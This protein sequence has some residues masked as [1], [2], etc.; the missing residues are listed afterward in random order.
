MKPLS[1]D[2]DWPLDVNVIRR[3]M[4]NHTFGMVRRRAD[5]SPRPHQGWDFHAA[6]GTQVHAVAAGRIVAVVTGKDYGLSIVQA[7]V[8]QG[9]ER[10]AAYCHLSSVLVNAGDAVR[11]GQVIGKTGDSG[12]AAGMKGADLHLHFELRDVARPG[13]GLD[14]RISP[15]ELFG[16]CPLSVPVKRKGLRP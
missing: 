1:P 12:N 8:H 10:F 3:G 6:I 14:G 13:P 16:H 7:F 4:V 9:C 15:L 5:G 2:I 11:L